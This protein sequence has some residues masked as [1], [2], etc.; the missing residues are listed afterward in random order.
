MNFINDLFTV[1][2][3]LV[4]FGGWGGDHAIL[5]ISRWPHNASSLW[6]VHCKI[7]CLLWT[8]SWTEHIKLFL[9]IS[10]I[11]CYFSVHEW[12]YIKF[13][14]D[15]FFNNWFFNL[16]LGW[17]KPYNVEFQVYAL[18]NIRI[19]ISS[20]LQWAKHVAYEREM[21]NAWQI[22]LEKP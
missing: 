17:R 11:I 7:S 22:F 15:S 19:T 20:R 9:G 1:V 18:L 14:N 21:S 5:L 2:N 4:F 12:L 10:I 16:K 13:D 6:T 3:R 8:V